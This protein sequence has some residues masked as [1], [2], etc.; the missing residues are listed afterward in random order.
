[1][2]TVGKCCQFVLFGIDP[3]VKWCHCVR[4]DPAH[5][6]QQNE[7]VLYPKSNRFWRPFMSDHILKL[8]ALCCV[9][10]GFCFINLQ[11]VLHK[12][13]KILKRADMV[14][15]TLIDVKLPVWKHR[16]QLAC[17]GHPVDTR[18]DDL[19]KWLELFCFTLL[20][21]FILRNKFLL[22]TSNSVFQ[23]QLF[24]LNTCACFILWA[25]FRLLLKCC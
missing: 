24:T 17:I 20:I 6:I 4:L 2:T 19:E 11:I 12:L 10:H 15:V 16:Q 18:L 21:F 8:L 5:Q 23:P 22:Y 7:T 25:G 1:M 9:Q 13:F 3:R 14:M